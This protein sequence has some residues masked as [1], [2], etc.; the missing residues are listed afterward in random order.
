MGRLKGANFFFGQGIFLGLF[1]M[2]SPRCSHQVL[3]MLS[4]FPMCFLRCCQ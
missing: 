3:K 2:C 1:P 4:K